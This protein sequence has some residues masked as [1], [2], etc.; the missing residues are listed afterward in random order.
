MSYT[1]RQDLRVGEKWG[2]K[3]E[4]SDECRA[5]KGSETAT[6]S[7]I[8]LPTGSERCLTQES[9]TTSLFPK[10]RCVSPVPRT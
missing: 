3:E 6:P 1:P 8:L 4:Q 2:K 10:V 5:L 7:K 9:G